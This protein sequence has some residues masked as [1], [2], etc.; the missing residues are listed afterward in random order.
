MHA[1]GAASNPSVQERGAATRNL[2]VVTRKDSERHQSTKG[3]TPCALEMAPESLE[4]G[5]W[6]ASN[7][8]ACPAR[9]VYFTFFL[10]HGLRLGFCGMLQGQAHEVFHKGGVQWQASVSRALFEANLCWQIFVTPLS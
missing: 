1:I 4:R 2:R 7:K 5:T 10:S 9:S 6:G 8:G 3:Q